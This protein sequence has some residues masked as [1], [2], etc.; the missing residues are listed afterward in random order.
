M[1]RNGF[2][3][4]ELLVVVAIIGIIAAVGVVAYSGYTSGA[5]QNAIKSRHKKIVKLFKAEF[6]KCNIG[7]KVYLNND[8]TFDQCQRILDPSKRHIRQLRNVL[9][10]HINNTMQW[11]D[12]YKREE[13][14]AINKKLNTIICELGKICLSRDTANERIVI[15]SNYDDNPENYLTSYLEL[16]N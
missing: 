7:E 3:L 8:D 6:E 13:E 5:K 16:D 11:K 15:V 2:T 12:I 14:A 1:N 4:I 10:L 9:I